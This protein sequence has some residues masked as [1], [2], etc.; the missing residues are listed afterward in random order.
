MSKLFLSLRLLVAPAAGADLVRGSV[1][2]RL[3]WCVS[4]S[5]WAAR[6]VEVPMR[7]IARIGELGFFETYRSD[8]RAQLLVLLQ[9]LL[10][11]M[12]VDGQSRGVCPESLFSQDSTRSSPLQLRR[13]LQFS[14][15]VK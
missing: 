13:L 14:T 8:W 3:Y 6:M 15:L 5:A 10:Q 2:F 9:Y 4:W 12:M 1:G 7:L 11:G